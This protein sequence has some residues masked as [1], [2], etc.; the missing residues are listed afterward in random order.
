MFNW[1]KYFLKNR[2]IEVRIGSELSSIYTIDNGTPQGSVCS[3]ILFNIMINDVFDGVN[4]RINRALYADD[5]ALWARGRNID[6]LQQKMQTAINQ[7]GKWSFK[8]EFHVSVEKTQF[9]CFSKKRVKPTVDLRIYGQSL[10]QVNELRYLGVWFDS[11]LTFKNH[12]QIMV[13]KCKKA[14]NQFKCLS[15]Y[16]LYSNNTLRV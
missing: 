15:G 10:K 14:I 4:Q 2:T 6:H 13:E 8:W 5:G 12:V 9:I 11:K 1:I 7:V 3:P 16:N